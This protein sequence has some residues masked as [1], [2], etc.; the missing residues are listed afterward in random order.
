MLNLIMFSKETK[1]KLA[2]TT[3]FVAIASFVMTTAAFA[4]P[5]K[6]LEIAIEADSRNKGVW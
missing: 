1:M 2:T 4:S 6:G 5:E 3:M